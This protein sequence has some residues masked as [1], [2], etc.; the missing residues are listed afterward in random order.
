MLKIAVCD[1]EP[2]FVEQI[3]GRIKKYMPDAAIQGFFSS[4]ELLSHGEVFDIYFLD[5]QMEKWMV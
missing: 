1:D 3:S 5:I 4:E 2:V